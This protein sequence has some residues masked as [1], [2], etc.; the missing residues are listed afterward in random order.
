[1]YSCTCILFLTSYSFIPNA[2]SSLKERSRSKQP[3]ADQQN[4]STSFPFSEKSIRCKA[5]LDGG[6]RPEEMQ[7]NFGRVISL[8]EIRLRVKPAKATYDRFPALRLPMVA[9]TRC[10]VCEQSPFYQIHPFQRAISTNT[11]EITNLSI[12][13]DPNEIILALDC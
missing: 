4:N 2:T 3:R 8:P 1:L 11:H 13:A 7:L 10:V 6:Q 12:F 9:L 5:H